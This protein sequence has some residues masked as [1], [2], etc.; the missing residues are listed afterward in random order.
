M[1][2]G[3]MVVFEMALEAVLGDLLVKQGSQMQANHLAIR[4]LGKMAVATQI[5]IQARQVR[6]EILA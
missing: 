3:G 5:A 2:E 4:C 6:K 1:V